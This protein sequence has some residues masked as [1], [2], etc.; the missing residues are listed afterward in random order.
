M[1]ILEKA[2]LETMT[3]SAAVRN[4]LISAS[5]MFNSI[6]TAEEGHEIKLNKFTPSAK[7][8]LK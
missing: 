1:D 8:K 7:K 6:C 5:D 3:E 4:G 2:P